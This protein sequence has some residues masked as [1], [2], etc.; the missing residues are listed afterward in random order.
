MTATEFIGMSGVPEA[1]WPNLADWVKWN[2]ENGLLGV[3]RNRP[4]GDILG[5][6]VARCLGD[7]EVP[8]PYKHNEDGDNVFVDLTI[9]SIDGKS[10]SLSRKT[11]KYLLKILWDRFGPRRGITFNRSGKYKE[12]DYIRFMRKAIA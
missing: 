8:E 1:T 7:G 9:T 10:S 4:G 2:E 12:Y 3:V 6:A 11:L 5:V